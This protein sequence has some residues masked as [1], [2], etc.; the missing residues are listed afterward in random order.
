MEY[1]LD[2]AKRAKG[3]GLAN[4]F[5]TNGYMTAEALDLITPYLDAANVDLKFF[6]DK[7]Y[8][9]VCAGSLDPVLDTIR[10]MRE[11][12][13]WVE[14]TTLVIPGQNDSAEELERIAAFIRSVGVEVPWHISLFH[15][16]YR[17]TDIGYTPLSKLNEAYDIGMRA[18]LRYVY[19]GNVA[20]E[21]NTSCYHCGEVLI[22]R[23]GFTVTENRLQGRRCPN[24]SSV[25]DGV[26]DI[27]ETVPKK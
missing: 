23:S 9:Q 20:E 13:I 5:V 11:K 21:E 8:R 15:P 27:R 6:N 10:R 16:D 22:R 25:I 24:C 18:G 2:V 3:R 17:L 26:Y 14:V 1:A 19:K 7:S 4:V 12:K